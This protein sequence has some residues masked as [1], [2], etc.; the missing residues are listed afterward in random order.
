MPIVL[1][2]QHRPEDYSAQDRQDLAR[3]RADHPDPG[4]APEQ[5]HA[6]G[7]WLVAGH[8]ND[9]MLAAAWLSDDGRHWQI[10]DLAVRALT[11]RRGVARQLLTL[12]QRE[13]D[14]AQR[15]LC[16]VDGPALQPLVPLLEELGF[17]RQPTTGAGAPRWQSPA[18]P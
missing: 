9:R 2:H 3:I 15:P 16:L 18:Q 13:A 6:Q 10:H 5:R 17:Q 4:P 12:L 1:Q 7:Q 14:E 11:R 8:F